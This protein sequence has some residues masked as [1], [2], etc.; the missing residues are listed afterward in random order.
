MTIIDDY[1]EYQAD[2]VKKYGDD[3]IVMMQVGH[4]YEA[5]GIDNSEESSNAENLYK[6]SDIMNIQLTRKSKKITENSRKNPLMIGFNLWSVNK[7]IDILTNNNYTIILIE[8]DRQGPNPERNITNIISPGINLDY[9]SKYDSNNLVCIYLESNKAYNNLKETISSGLSCIDITTGKNLIYE[10]HTD[11][12]DKNLVLDEIFRFI[13]VHH[14][15]EIV[16]VKK[17]IKQS[18]QELISYLDIN[19]CKTH[20]S[21]IS[22][23]DKKFLN[24]NYQK[25][26]LTK[27]FKNNGM[28]SIIEYLDLEYK[29]FGLLSYIILLDFAYDHN[30]TIINNISKP[31]ITNN[32]GHLILTN[33]TINQ[34]NVVNHYSKCVNSKFDS[35][36][37]VVNNNSTAIGKRLLKERLLSP[38]T[39]IE[40]LEKRYKLTEIMMRRL[41]DEYIY[42]NY[43]KCLNKIND[44]ER[45]HRKIS[46]KVLQP[47]DFGVLDT[48]YKNVNLIIQ[49]LIN[50]PEI[51]EIVPSKKVC[52]NFN[53]FIEEYTSIFNLDEIIKYHSDKIDNS[54][55]NSG[56]NDEIDQL[57]EKIDNIHYIF[58][59]LATK[60]SNY[61]EKDSKFIKIDN[62]E[63]NGYYLHT[64]DKRSKILIDRMKN[65]TS[66]FYINDKFG[67]KIKISPKD[68]SLKDAT[69]S[70][71]K[72][73]LKLVKE[74]SLLLISYQDKMK[75][76][77]NNLFIKYLAEFES[78]YISDLSEISKF[79]GIIDNIKSNAKTSLKY[80]YCRPKILES[81]SSF[82]DVKGLR[83]PIIER[84]NDNIDYIDNDLTLDNNLNGMLLF[85]TNASG[86]SSLMKA[87]GL[88]IIMAQAGLFCSSKNFTYYPFN[89]IFSRI[90]NNDNIFKGESSFAVEMSE[91]RSI[92]KRSDS[93]SIVLGDE[94]CNGTES[95]SAQSIFASSVMKLSER[96][97]KFIFATHLHELCKL[98]EITNIDNMKMY[99][100]KVIFDKENDKLIYDRKLEEGS[101]P[102]IYGL[103]VCKAMDMDDDFLQTANKIRRKLLNIDKNILEDK[104]SNYNSK[105]ILDK[106]KI[107]N[108]YATEVHHIKFQSEADVNNMIDHVPKNNKSNL[109]Q[110]CERCHNS[111]HNN[112]LMIKGY[113]Q[114]SNGLELDY[115]YLENSKH[116][117]KKKFNYEMINTINSLKDYKTTKKNICNI[118]LEKHSIKISVS[119]LNKIWNNNY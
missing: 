119:T 8:Q 62:N 85:G 18:N 39:D 35:L 72:I 56:I 14:P 29:P 37:G 59:A 44:I 92:L 66:N 96:K 38:I 49:N 46:L 68:I 30:E 61:I 52:Q 9:C 114:T 102:A 45:L 33:N 11:Y 20:I 67:N 105:I 13:Q 43:E 60:L 77:S 58:E 2:F 84:I 88:N 76:L 41:D 51:N 87:I 69:K 16:L 95:I 63:K 86:K 97:C 24:I 31:E 27:V 108:E 113:V 90:N 54:F 3:T 64:T 99:H 83:H 117:S 78:K 36:Y 7:Y 28:L 101:G 91:L 70:S 109:V 17:N 10:S 50:T 75:Y 107:C 40:E 118:L 74:N 25:D 106:C 15:K 26:F 98:D 111:V 71:T 6:L 116:N 94:L 53:K 48:S 4:F 22:E 93:N 42:N 32:S 12:Y 5:Y 112:N 1:L 82:I 103:E 21:D 23:I 89:Y 104:K 55:Y 57:Q 79:V 100:L 80:N 81:E 73:N 34:L 110:L 19:N 115:K 65:L 47:A